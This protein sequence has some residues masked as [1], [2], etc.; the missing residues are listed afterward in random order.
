M[1]GYLTWSSLFRFSGKNFMCI[2]KIFP[3]VLHALLILGPFFVHLIALMIYN[4]Q[5]KLWSSSLCNFLK[6]PFASSVFRTYIGAL[7]YL[8]T[9]AS[10]TP[11]SHVTYRNLKGNEMYLLDVTRA[12]EPKENFTSPSLNTVSRTLIS[13]DIYWTTRQAMYGNVTLKRFR[14]IV[15]V[16]E[17]Q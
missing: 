17:K 8:T 12:C 11:S 2:Y 15:V 9:V 13:S 3:C 1:S 16:V 4:E 5:W 7:F 6:P 10:H 14:I